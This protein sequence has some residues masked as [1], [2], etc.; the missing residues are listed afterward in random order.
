MKLIGLPDDLYAYLLNIFSSYCQRG[1]VP[2][3][4]SG[5][6]ALNT[7]LQ[8]AQD[9]DF[10]KLGPAKI[11]NMGENG[12]EL[13]LS[14]E[15][16]EDEAP[17]QRIGHMCSYENFDDMPFECGLPEGHSGP[18]ENRARQNEFQPPLPAKKQAKKK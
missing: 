11:V 7:R 3:E 12:V 14:D 6:A 18:H 13:E 5:A 2:E 16:S 15:T 17:L 10:S 9:V 4:L 8:C 1:L